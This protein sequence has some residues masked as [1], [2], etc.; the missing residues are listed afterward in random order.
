MRRVGEWWKVAVFGCVLVAWCSVG[1]AEAR[2]TCAGSVAVI[3]V[4]L[5]IVATTPPSSRR[6][7]F[8]L[9]AY[10]LLMLAVGVALGLGALMR[11]YQSLGGLLV[12]F[13]VAPF[14]EGPVR[15]LQQRAVT[16]AGERIWPVLYFMFGEPDPRSVPPTVSQSKPVGAPEAERTSLPM[17]HGPPR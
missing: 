15:R 13:V 7:R 14:L 3:L 1:G 17:R 12:L 8:G 5:L 10:R 11:G 6:R 9:V 2:V 4:L 16:P